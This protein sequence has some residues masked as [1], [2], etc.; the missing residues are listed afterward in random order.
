MTHLSQEQ[1]AHVRSG[2]IR[3]GLTILSLFTFF[4]D[5]KYIAL[6][7]K[8]LKKLVGDKKLD[9]RASLRAFFKDKF[10]L[11]H[12]S[13]T[14]IGREAFVRIQLENQQDAFDWTYSQL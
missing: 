8:T 9:R 10:I 12:E 13:T 3:Y 2:C 14:Q 1:K 6:C 11:Q 5:F 7:S 4:E